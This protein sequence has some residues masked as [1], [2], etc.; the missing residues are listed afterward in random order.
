MTVMP[1]VLVMSNL[2]KVCFLVSLDVPRD[3]VL[4]L[5]LMGFGHIM[6]LGCGHCN[7]GKAHGGDNGCKDCLLEFHCSDLPGL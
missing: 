1:L 4:L 5:D 2:L 3:L 7:G 6:G